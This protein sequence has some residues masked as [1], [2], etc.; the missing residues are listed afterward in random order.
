MLTGNHIRTAL[1]LPL[2]TALICAECHRLALTYALANMRVVQQSLR[3]TSRTPCATNVIWIRNR[4]QGLS[5]GLS[6]SIS[7]SDVGPIGSGNRVV[8]TGRFRA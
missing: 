7:R 6:G 8:S 1:A 4:N 2:A 3:M 5:G